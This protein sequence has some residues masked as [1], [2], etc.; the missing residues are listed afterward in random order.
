MLDCVSIITS[1][2]FPAQRLFMRGTGSGRTVPLRSVISCRGAQETTPTGLKR[3]AFQ[4]SYEVWKGGRACV[5]A[6]IQTTVAQ[7][8]V[9]GCGVER[10]A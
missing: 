8:T 4:R 7:R 2:L 9:L 3:I 5:D 10:A 6:G 1:P